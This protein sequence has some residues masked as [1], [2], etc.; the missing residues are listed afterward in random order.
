MPAS[1]HTPTVFFARDKQPFGESDD[2]RQSI[3]TDEPL[4]VIESDLVDYERESEGSR[5]AP[6]EEDEDKNKGGEEEDDAE[7]DRESVA[8]AKRSFS[9]EEEVPDETPK[10]KAGRPPKRQRPAKVNKKVSPRRSTR[11][12]SVASS[13]DEENPKPAKAPVKRGRGRSPSKKKE[14]V[15][16]KAPGANSS[17]RRSGRLAETKKT[18]GESETEWEVEKIMD[19][20]IDVPTGVHLYLV[21]W[22]GFS[23][24]QNT[25][26][27]KKNLG[28]CLELIREFEKRH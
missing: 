15:T 17:T 8:P 5:T 1:K 20:G 10:R 16:V 28:N 26:E 12:T 2:P 23:G 27:P 22:K 14:T 18:D 21:K 25:W 19:S 7:D 3:E 9:P 11:L 6:L 13:R 4:V 24:K